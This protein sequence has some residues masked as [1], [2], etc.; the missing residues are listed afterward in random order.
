VATE[1]ALT[2]GRPLRQV[3]G[4]LVWSRPGVFARE[5][6]LEAG[7]ERLAVLRW[8]KVLG[9]GAEGESM[10]GRWRISGR[11]GGALN[12]GFVVKDAASDAEV[13]VMTRNWRGRGEVRFASG[14]SY[15]WDREG[16]WHPEHFWTSATGER[17][18]TWRA[19][20]G[21]TI[22]YE[23][24]VMEGARR[25]DELPV[26]VMLGTYVMAMMSRQRHAS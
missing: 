16:F 18:V 11:R 19:R 22:R 20:I 5:L 1:A 24:E 3:Y 14:A 25:L 8:P 6:R 2:T 17:L 26:L 12:L 15:T 21:W 9:T 7:S 10:D 4:D 13:A 23:M